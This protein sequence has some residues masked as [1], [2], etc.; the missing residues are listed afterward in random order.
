MSNLA[1]GVRGYWDSGYCAG[2]TVSTA[3]SALQYSFTKLRHNET[4]MTA[5]V[6]D[7]VKLQR[8]RKKDILVMECLINIKEG[9]K[10]KIY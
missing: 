10:I 1:T 3:D 4:E 8:A 6:K 2:A 9:D 7:K 5:R